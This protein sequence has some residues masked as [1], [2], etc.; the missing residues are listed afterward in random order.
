MNGLQNVSDAFPFSLGHVQLTYFCSWV[1]VA[2]SCDR[3][4]I[5]NMYCA[6][7]ESFTRVTT[8]AT[9]LC[10]RLSVFVCMFLRIEVY[11][12]LIFCRHAGP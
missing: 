1:D 8:K 4:A 7:G 5:S 10:A 6:P 3:E 11:E 2:E 12:G 9:S